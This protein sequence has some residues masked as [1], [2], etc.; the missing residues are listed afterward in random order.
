ML[1]PGSA[2]LATLAQLT[3]VVLVSQ[4]EAM[5][6]VLEDAIVGPVFYCKVVNLVKPIV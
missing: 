4:G 3:L 5:A 6:R 1:H 2:G